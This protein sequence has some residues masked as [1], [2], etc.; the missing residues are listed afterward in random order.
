MVAGQG[1][2]IHL[3]TR[4]VMLGRQHLGPVELAELDPGVARFHGRALVDAHSSLRSLSSPGDLA[5]ADS[6]AELESE[7][8]P[9]EQADGNPDSEKHEAELHLTSTC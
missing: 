4:Q 6:P 7:K 3:F 8:H 5:N 2:T 9:E 1:V